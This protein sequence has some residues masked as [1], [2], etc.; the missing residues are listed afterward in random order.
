MTNNRIGVEV[1]VKY[2]GVDKAQQNLQKQVKNN[3][4]G[5]EMDL[6]RGINTKIQDFA[7]TIG[8][9]FNKNFKDM[10]KNS[11]SS[12]DIENGIKNSFDIALSDI[13]TKMSQTATKS[14]ME[15]YEGFINEIKGKKFSLT[16]IAFDKDELAQI[17]AGIQGTLKIDSKAIGIDS[18][19]V[20]L[21]EI[22]QKW[23][24]AFDSSV[25]QDNVLKLSEVISQYKQLK[26]T[27]VSDG[28]DSEQER[29]LLGRTTVEY[30]KLIDW[31][32]E[33]NS[34]K[35]QSAV[36]TETATKKEI[37]LLDELKSKYKDMD[38]NILSTGNTKVNGELTSEF[39]KAR[40]E[41]GELVTI[42]KQGN[43]TIEK[44][45][46]DTRQ[47]AEQMGKLR[48]NS[49][50]KTKTQDRKL[51]VSQAQAINKAKEEEYKL[52]QKLAVAVEKTKTEYKAQ[53]DVIEKQNA[54]VL[55]SAKGVNLQGQLE[56]FRNELNNL[57]PQNMNELNKFV[58]SL[59]ANLKTT[60]TDISVLGKEMSNAT[61]NVNTF[62]GAFSEA[63]RKVGLFSASYLVI[64]KI[65][66]SF[67][68][69]IE[70][71]KEM[72]SA[73]TTLKITMDGMST[74]GLQSMVKQSQDLAT[75]LSSTTTDV[76]KIVKV[77][78]NANETVE[79]IMAKSKGATILSNLSGIDSSETAKTILS[80][81]NQFKE[82]ANASE[83]DIM[84]IADSIVSVSRAL[85]LDFSEGV[86]GA[87]EGIKILGSL[88]EQVGMSLEET[89][90]VL[91]STV[92]KTQMTFSEV[93]TSYKTIISRIY[94]Q[95]DVT[96][97][98][99]LKA[100]KALN[101]VGIT[102]KDTEGNMKDYMDI[103]NELGN[104]FEDLSEVEQNYL[105]DALGGARQLNVVLAGVQN[106]ARTNEL[107]SLAMNSSGEAMKANEIY[108]ESLEGRL[109]S[110]KNTS[111]VFWQNFFD[112]NSLKN[113]ISGFDGLIR[114]LDR[115]QNTFGTLG[116]TV[117]VLSASF[118]TFTNN[119]LKNFATGI[120]KGGDSVTNFQK[121]LTTTMNT[122]K[123][124]SGV[125]SKVSVGIKGLGAAFNTAGVQA[126]ITTVKIAALQTALSVGVGIVIGGVISGLSKLGDSL[127]QTRQELSDLN[128]EFNSFAN[129]DKSSEATKLINE[130]EK[131]QETLLGV[132]KNSK[133]YNETEE[134]LAVIQE[135]IIAL[136]PQAS[137]VIDENTG[138]KSLNLEA[139]K[140]LTEAELVLANAKAEQSLDDNKITNISDVERVI[141]EY[142]GYLDVLTQV[143]EMKANGEKSRLIDTNDALSQTGKLNINVKD[144]DVYTTR[145]QNAKETL[146]TVNNATGILSATN[147]EWATA[148]EKTSKSLGIVAD[149]LIELGDNA[150]EAADSLGKTENVLTDLNYDGVVDATDAMLALAEATDQ[151]KSAVENLGNQFSA[152]QGH[153]DL[154][155][156]MKEEFSEYGMLDTSTVAK[157]LNTGD[158]QLVALLGDEANMLQN[159]NSLLETKAYNQ[160]QI[161]QHAIRRANEE[162]G[163]SNLIVDGL[164]VEEQAIRSLV[165]TK[166]NVFTQS[167]NERINLESEVVNSNLA[168][169][170]ADNSNQIA[171]ENSKI[172]GSFTSASQRINNEKEVVD[173]NLAN[174]KTEDKN[175]VSLANSKIKS[176]DAVAN[177]AIQGTAEMVSINNSNYAIDAA[178]YASYINSKIESYRAF[179]LAQNG[180]FTLGS[181]G[182]KNEINALKEYKN[183][184]DSMVDKI[185]TSM[186]NTQSTYG[187]SGGI[188]GGVS[189]GSLGTGTSGSGGTGGKSEAQKAE[190]AYQKERE[191]LEKEAN[192]AI[193]S[194]RDKLVNALKKKYESLRD[195][196]LAVYDKE[197]EMKQKEL[198]RLRN[199]YVDE[200]EKILKLEK[201]LAMWEKNDSARGQEMVAELKQQLAEAKLEKE[202]NDLEAQKEQVNKKYDAML[203][204]KKLY[205]EANN[206]IVNKSYQTQLDLLKEFGDGFKDTMLMV[207]KT[208]SQ[209]IQEEIEYALEGLKYIKGQGNNFEN[210]SKNRSI[211]S[212]DT[213]GYTPSNISRSGALAIL[214]DNE[215]I[216]NKVE[217]QYFKSFMDDTVP[218]INTLVNA[219]GNVNDNLSTQNITN[220]GD[221]IFSPTFNVTNKTEF[222][223][224]NFE[225]NIEKG[226]RKELR[227]LGRRV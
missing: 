225:F 74:S 65:R 12:G 204:D 56:G 95:G 165:Q 189:H 28:L 78:A 44:T 169:Y 130:Y 98:E 163:V 137:T 202:I 119:P 91:S 155:N 196:E 149:E 67:K 101:A 144:L 184:Y 79:S 66:S 143:N 59:K 108:A 53:L 87:G 173:K 47:L 192:S 227:K 105:G 50:I 206:M 156:Q 68:E 54:V 77:F 167:A 182:L 186:N 217:T 19:M 11:L 212:Y 102:I 32:E 82:F 38:A 223:A 114:G 152:L 55:N 71:V 104:K 72:D 36:T 8:A 81:T 4:V 179:A 128:S 96:G 24:F 127:I 7:K 200:Q 121:N 210:I 145:L 111:Q 76:L 154:L 211:A 141:K 52:A 70:A 85:K 29:L 64:N 218:K 57:N 6:P 5:I 33:V 187:G 45:V 209:V 63:L 157:V 150:E 42:I 9:T 62:G 215:R 46:D 115:V 112:S 90:G 151:G 106:M 93:A 140:K 191:R 168:N 10:L 26:K 14:A 35:K 103:M 185:T 113:I 136:Y 199:G 61:K 162:I 1:E 92:E 117:G 138:K 86:S 15:Q 160:E 203:D 180:G 131:L 132:Q 21:K 16:N 159:I 174:Y 171:T 120:V 142:E 23:G 216:L 188:S 100:E 118:L 193:S 133:I 139:T 208:I 148:N 94:R 88:S 126:A 166:S 146:E 178:N 75:A 164:S 60:K 147:E 181:L 190:E 25:I 220:N 43:D 40:N 80:A 161:Y 172:R 207:G 221:V 31:I 49:E 69:G 83:S 205:E 183:E 110:L 51:E 129:G 124:T 135:K 48:E 34:A 219:M 84:R 170:N 41:A 153:I 13:N 198:D 197:I 30:I 176:A 222:D 125:A 177:A 158:A 3:P 109:T 107:T 213:G 175:F 27:G 122:V 2:T 195:K 22:G 39:V 73:V 226:I 116:T 134:E 18:L 37:S 201:E 123:A 224:K 58:D 99:A 20:D 194:Q 89:L 97:E 17:K 214:H